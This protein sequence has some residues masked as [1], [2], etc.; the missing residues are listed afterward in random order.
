MIHKQAIAEIRDILIRTCDGKQSRLTAG[1]LRYLSDQLDALQQGFSSDLLTACKRVADTATDD[2]IRGRAT[3][4]KIIA[5]STYRI[6]VE[7]VRK[8]TK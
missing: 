1:R 6:V 4:D 2:K 7:A 3:G 5:G 8:A